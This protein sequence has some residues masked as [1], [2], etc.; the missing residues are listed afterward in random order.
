MTA[1]L[2]AFVVI[3]AVVIVTALAIGLGRDRRPRA[4][5]RETVLAAHA[6]FGGVTAN[7]RVARL[8]ERVRRLE[9]LA[10]EHGRQHLP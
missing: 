2:L 6:W 10:H 4:P 3:P 9:L 1:L 7:Q 8:E 5:E